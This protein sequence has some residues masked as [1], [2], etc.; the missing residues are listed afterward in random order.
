M[1]IIINKDQ[2]GYKL[3]SST[4]KENLHDEEFINED[5][6][7]VILINKQFWEFI[8]SVI[9]INFD[10]P[11]GYFINNQLQTGNLNG[12]KLLADLYEKENCEEL[13]FDKF[14]EVK[15][16]LKLDFNITTNT[17]NND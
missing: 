17:E 15:E 16:K 5:Q 4:T 8:E 6:V 7:K 3:S 9:R 10:F 13:I 11:N 1:S 14:T 2:N 12:A